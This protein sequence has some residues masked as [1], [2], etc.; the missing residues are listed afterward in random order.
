MSSWQVRSAIDDVTKYYGSVVR[1]S[2]ASG[3]FGMM[4]VLLALAGGCSKTPPPTAEADAT[5]SAQRA[6]TAVQG[7]ATIGVKKNAS[8]TSP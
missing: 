6:S 5:A 2:K 7:S 1:M 3:S 4:A 8:E